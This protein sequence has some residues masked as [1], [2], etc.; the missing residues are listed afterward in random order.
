MVRLISTGLMDHHLK[1]LLWQLKY[2]C[3]RLI[4]ICMA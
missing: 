3:F 4:V 2:A 1:S